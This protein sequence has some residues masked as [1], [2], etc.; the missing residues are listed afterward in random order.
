LPEVFPFLQFNEA[1]KRVKCAT[2]G[3]IPCGEIPHVADISGQAN[4]HTSPFSDGTFF[5]KF[6]KGLN[7]LVTMIRLI[8]I[9]FALALILR[10]VFGLTLSLLAGILDRI[11]TRILFFLSS[12]F[13]SHYPEEFSPL[14]YQ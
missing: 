8:S 5:V 14:D 7:K 12:K 1:H 11:L 9:L 13:S 2:I 4:S 6:Q 10:F 3:L